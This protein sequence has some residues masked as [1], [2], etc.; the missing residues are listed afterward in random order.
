V[1]DSTAQQEAGSIGPGDVAVADSVIWIARLR[2]ARVA[3]FQ[4]SVSRVFKLGASIDSV[5]AVEDSVVVIASA[6]V[7]ED[8]ADL[9]VIDSVVAVDLVAVALG[10]LEASGAVEAGLEEAGDDKN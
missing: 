2:T 5:V 3:I 7:V 4:A 10:A 8:L 6:A 1:V 9:A